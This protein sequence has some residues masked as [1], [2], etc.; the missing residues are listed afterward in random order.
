MKYVYHMTLNNEERINT[1]YIKRWD[2]AMTL[3]ENKEDIKIDIDSNEIKRNFKSTFLLLVPE[4][5]A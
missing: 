2:N 4:R 3:L 1:F 5:K